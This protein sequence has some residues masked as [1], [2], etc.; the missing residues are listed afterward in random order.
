[1]VIP[2]ITAYG[3][4]NRSQHEGTILDI[5]KASEKA[6]WKDLQRLGRNSNKTLESAVINEYFLL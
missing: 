5:V 2:N 1:M 3:S 4:M 6:A